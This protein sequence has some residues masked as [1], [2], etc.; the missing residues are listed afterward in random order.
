MLLQAS[1]N[2]G[3]WWSHCKGREKQNTFI[4]EQRERC[5]SKGISVG[6]QLVSASSSWP[7][8]RWNLQRI[9][10]LGYR[11]SS[12]GASGAKGRGWIKL[13][14]RLLE[15]TC[16]GNGSGCQKV[17]KPPGPWLVLW[18]VF[19][20]FFFFFFF[21]SLCF[22]FI[23]QI[24]SGCQIRASALWF[25]H[26]LDG[27]RLGSNRGLGLHYRV[28]WEKWESSLEE[29]RVQKVLFVLQEFNE[30]PF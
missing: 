10:E 3:G 7:S 15:H 9:S 19:V 11:S 22:F 26:S 6:L 29:M 4:P 21:W 27:D 18:V 2:P 16:S 30:C 14:C 1:L 5:E 12:K 17:S 28:G 13:F 25:Q 23:F 24:W 20:V 8:T